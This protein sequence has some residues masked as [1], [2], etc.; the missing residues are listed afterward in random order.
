M[1]RAVLSMGL[2]FLCFLDHCSLAEEFLSPAFPF[3]FG[4]ASSAFPS[5]SLLLAFAR[6]V[7]TNIAL[8]IRETNDMSP[9]INLAH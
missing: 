7:H 5:N 3:I 4:T 9:V 8:E 1:N 6:N 2:F